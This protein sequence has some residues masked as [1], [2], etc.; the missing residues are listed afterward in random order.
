MEQV[1]RERNLKEVYSGKEG[2]RESGR[3]RG[4]EVKM[5]APPNETKSRDEEEGE[6]TRVYLLAQRS[7]IKENLLSKAPAFQTVP[8]TMLTFDAEFEMEESI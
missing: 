7:K 8:T 4:R 3:Q 2:G 1:V 6:E 5:A